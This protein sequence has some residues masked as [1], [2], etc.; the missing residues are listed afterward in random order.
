MFVV[1]VNTPITTVSAESIIA[2]NQISSKSGIIKSYNEKKKFGF[3]KDD[4]SGKQIY[5]NESGLIDKPINQGDKV[6]FDVSEGRS[7]PI[8][9]NVRK[10]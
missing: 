6:T 1:L 7:G 4:E 3:I 9:V 10:I 2:V 8:A 5:F